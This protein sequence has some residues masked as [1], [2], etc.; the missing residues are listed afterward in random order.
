MLRHIRSVVTSAIFWS[1]VVKLAHATGSFFV[2]LLLARLAGAEIVGQFALAI[3]TAT[4]VG[5][6]P[7]AGMDV[8][9]LRT[10]SGDL[11]QGQTGA[12]RGSWR[13]FVGRTALAALLVMLLFLAAVL[14]S[15]LAE[16]LQADRQAILAAAIGI[17]SAP[18]FRLSIHGIRA[19]GLPV[20]GQAFEALPSMMLALIMLGLA[21]ANSVPPL[22]LVVGLMVAGQLLATLI[23]Q[24]L[25][26]H[27]SRGWQEA[28]LPDRAQR[29]AFRMAGLPMMGVILLH[30]F[31]DWFILAATTSLA[32]AADTGAF[33]AALQIMTL[34][35]V[36][37]I[38]ADTY[39][40]PRIGGD[41]RSGQS[42][43]AWRR[44]RRAT[45]L[46][47]AL[48][49]PILLLALLVPQWVLVTL[50]GGEFVSAAPALRIMAIGL[51]VR[52]LAGPS[53]TMMVMAGH[54]RIQFVLALVAASVQVALSLL[55]IPRLGL[56][57]AA[58]AYAVTI[59]FRSI[60]SLV[61]ARH[62]IRP[63][64]TT[65]GPALR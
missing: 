17:F 48:A 12:A 53:G 9:A 42:A 4:L 22:W 51:L 29:R 47:V 27:R 43:L 5:M 41:L 50:F 21:M 61:L 6:V 20:H 49:S 30:Q 28:I 62:L 19:L 15:P 44:H 57:G 35:T 46:T 11:R 32:S 23:A 7:L 55:L 2:T 24:L 58:I 34:V 33:R 37:A 8:I 52:S 63:A 3:A 25:F 39:V 56:T 1:F 31:S 13:W 45:L 54:E 40:A 65:S 10:V 16:Q 14:L 60:A 18:I 64:V 26:R 36:V 59:S 38:T